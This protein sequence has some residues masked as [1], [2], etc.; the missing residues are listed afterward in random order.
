[1]LRRAD[2]RRDVVEG[3]RITSQ[4][5]LTLNRNAGQLNRRL[6]LL[7]TPPEEPDYQELALLA[8]EEPPRRKSLQSSSVRKLP[9]RNK[10]N[11]NNVNHPAKEKKKSG[12]KPSSNSTRKNPA[13]DRS[14]QPGKAA[15]NP[16]KKS[17]SPGASLEKKAKSLS[18]LDCKTKKS[19]SLKRK[20]FSPQH[21]HRSGRL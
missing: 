17:K 9:G 16:R 20:S 3:R 8:R 7:I 13:T 15:S 19:K 6:R 12:G 11:C 5:P 18:R 2:H 1:M 14:E 21:S 10:E 4:L